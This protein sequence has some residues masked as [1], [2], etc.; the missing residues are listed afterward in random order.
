[1]EAKMP[2]M[3]TTIMSSI[4]V[5]PRWRVYFMVSPLKLG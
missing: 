3:A 1:M 4:K 2:M 5:K